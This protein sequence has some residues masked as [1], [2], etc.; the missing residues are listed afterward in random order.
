M[1]EL[2]PPF[3]HD[4]LF[5]MLFVK[6]PD[7]LRHLVAALLDLRL[8][9]IQEFEISN[10]E[11]PPEILGGKFCRLDI[12]MV[13]DGQRVDLE[14][15]V[16]DEQDYPERSLYYW[17]R[18]YSSALPAGNEYAT[19]PRVVVISI[20]DFTLFANSTEFHSEFQVL[21]VTRYTPLTDRLVLHYFELPKLPEGVAPNDAASLWLALF[22]AKT[23][24][25]LH[26]LDAMGVTFVDQAITAYRAIT[27]DSMFRELERLRE[28]AG[29][30]EASALANARREGRLEGRLEG[31]YEGQQEET[32]KWQTM[33]SDLLLLGDN[34][35]IV[36]QLRAKLGE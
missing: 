13:V 34:E 16:A 4:L 32:Q 29:H 6:Y 28:L 19:L 2:K 5:K 30:N 15:Q 20:V 23:E 31:R 10:P 3:T 36:A 35:A 14:V 24:E 17:A 25:E 18:D 21:E 9:S 1:T 11:L 7:L 33:M 12:N 22:K 8:E 27:A 26:R